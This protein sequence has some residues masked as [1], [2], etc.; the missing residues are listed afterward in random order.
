MLSFNHPN[1]VGCGIPD[2]R[3]VGAPE[4]VLEVF[5]RDLE[6]GYMAGAGNPDS[7]WHTA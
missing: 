1:P 5:E 3:P 7:L 2:T 4:R 6:G